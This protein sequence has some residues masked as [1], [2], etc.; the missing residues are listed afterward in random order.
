MN[1]SS[2]II[3][4][5]NNRVRIYLTI[6]FI[7]I[8][9]FVYMR[10][11]PAFLRD[12]SS[13]IYSQLGSPTRPKKNLD[14]SRTMW[15]ITNLVPRKNWDWPEPKHGLNVGF[16]HDQHNPLYAFMSSFG[17][18]ILL[19]PLIQSTAQSAGCRTKR[20]IW[21]RLKGDGGHFILTANFE[22]NLPGISFF[23]L[24][25][26]RLGLPSTLV[27]WTNTE[28]PKSLAQIFIVNEKSFL[29]SENVDVSRRILNRCT[30]MYF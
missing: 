27:F 19:P 18:T 30:L 5:S 21:K 10:V 1:L 15:S 14:Y 11:A 20:Q 26:L 2:I 7:K 6:Y 22:Q 8:Q 16:S 13:S 23:L 9:L 29:A 3:D 25:K 24:S 17:K 4:Q 12:R 28:C